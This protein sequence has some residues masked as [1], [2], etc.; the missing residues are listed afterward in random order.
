[1][2]NS[3]ETSPILNAQSFD[4]P[5]EQHQT[6]SKKFLSW[7]SDKK[8]IIAAGS[9][10]MA[11]AYD[12]FV[13]SNVMLIMSKKYE[14]NDGYRALISSGA[15]AGAVFGQ[16]F[17]GALCD[18]F[19]R[20][21]I[22]IITVV[23]IVLASVA[24]ACIFEAPGASIYLFLG[25]CRIIL[26]VGVG[27]EYPLGSA[28]ASESSTDTKTRDIRV[29]AV[30][31]MQGIGNALSAVVVIICLL[32]FTDI[33]YVWRIALGFGAIPSIMAFILR[34]TMHESREFQK[35]QEEKLVWWR[36]IYKR[37]DKIMSNH[38][39]DLLGT[40]GTWLI[41]DIVFYGNALF[42]PTI[43]DI[44]GFE[45]THDEHRNLFHAALISFIVSLIALPG[46]FVAAATIRR[47]GRKNIQVCE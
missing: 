30:F 22:S 37:A 40:A 21:A 27:G 1:M 26:G 6:R 12:L 9:G 36:E 18:W 16:L 41:F 15:L 19:G 20:K 38:K 14:L 31:S 45:K 23:I 28:M 25:I 32:I 8:S 7:L 3:G 2:S 5:V 47:F 44:V 46:Y 13:I 43:A 24:S 34:V 39:K 17:F 11:D 33:E 4:E 42:L 10:F 29:A 35:I